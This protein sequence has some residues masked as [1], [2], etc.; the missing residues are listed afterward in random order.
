MALFQIFMSRLKFFSFE[1]LSWFEALSRYW[2][3][4]IFAGQHYIKR[5]FGAEHHFLSLLSLHPGKWEFARDVGV[6]HR[7]NHLF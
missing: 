2:L 1:A 4:S 6:V 7:K 5:Y 3:S